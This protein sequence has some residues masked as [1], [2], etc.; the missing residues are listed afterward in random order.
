MGRSEYQRFRP[1]P[2]IRHTNFRKLTKLAYSLM[3]GILK[4]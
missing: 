2:W 1:W 4:T 3:R